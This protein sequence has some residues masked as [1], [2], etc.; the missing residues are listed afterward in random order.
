MS[1]RDDYPAICAV[2]GSKLH[3]DAGLYRRDGEQ[4]IAALNEIDQLRQLLHEV[5]TSPAAAPDDY[6]DFFVRVSRETWAAVCAI[7]ARTEQVQP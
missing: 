7:D 1:A 5:A 2:A 6:A 3:N 4:M